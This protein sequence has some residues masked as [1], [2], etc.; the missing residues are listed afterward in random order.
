MSLELEF[1]AG[2]FFDYPL[3]KNKQYLYKYF[4][5]EPQRQFVRYYLLFGNT[6]RYVEHTGSYCSKRW[7]FKL[8]QK[9]DYLEST[10]QKARADND[11]S[12]VGEIES[13]RHKCNFISESSSV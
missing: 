11:F 9:L 4:K 2:N 5:P 8:K 6:T 12:L 7:L 13:G 1:I 3:P 10:L